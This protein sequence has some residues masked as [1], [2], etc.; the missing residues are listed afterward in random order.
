MFDKKG[1]DITELKLNI[2]RLNEIIRLIKY[3]SLCE[4]L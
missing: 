2:Y 3:I 4:K 1:L